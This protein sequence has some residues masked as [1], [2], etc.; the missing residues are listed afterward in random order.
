MLPAAFRQE[1]IEHYY[2]PYRS[3]V[4]RLITE[5]YGDQTGGA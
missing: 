1:I 3:K 2:Q 4:E 5:E